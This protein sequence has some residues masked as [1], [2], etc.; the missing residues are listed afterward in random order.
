[1]TEW[2][3]FLSTIPI[4]SFFSRTELEAIHDLF[5]EV[6]YDKGDT[7]CRIGDEG[8]TFY[9]VLSGEL[10]VWG[11][12]QEQRLINTLGPRDFF[13][14]MAILQ[15]GKR[16][17]TIRASRRTRLLS[18]AKADFE[19]LFLKNP[20]AIEYFARVLCKRLASITRGEGGRKQTTVITVTGRPGLKGKTI[21]ATALAGILKDVTGAEVLLV[22]VRPGSNGPAAA[23]AELVSDDLGI[24][25]EKIRRE[26]SSDA[27]GA[28]VLTVDVGQDKPQE[29]YGKG[30]SNLVGK[31]S[32]LFP[33]ILFDLGSEPKAL[34]DSVGAFTD[35]LIEIVDEPVATSAS[36][37]TPDTEAM[38]RLQVINLFN[39]TSKRIPIS[40]CEP[41][42]IPEDSFLAK[43][44]STAAK[45]I[46]E[47]GRTP[48]ALPIHRLARKLLGSSVGLAL[49]GGAAF[50]IAHLGVLKVLE[51]NK[52]PIDLI[53]GCSQGS[54]IGVGYAAGI[55]TDEMIAIARRLGKLKNIL[56]PID[57]TLTKPGILGGRRMIGIFSPLLKGKVTFE[58]LVLPCRTIATDIETGE[59]IAIGTGRLDEAFRASS[60]VPMVFAPF[61][62]GERALVDGGVADPCP[63]GVVHEMGADLCIAV[64]VVPPLK[65]GVENV[66][67]RLYRRINRLNP[68]SYLG[69][70]ADLPNLFDIVM[71]AM[72]ILQYELGNFKAITADVLINPDLSDFT[73]IEYYRA[74]ELIRRGAEAAERV[75]PAIQKAIDE[76]LAPARKHVTEAVPSVRSDVTAEAA[77][78]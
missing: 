54:I 16:T 10:E 3:D 25:T 49:G 30:A 31:V 24:A 5:V 77:N 65:R 34:V 47:N 53:A 22:D 23:I 28:A 50:G 38:K 46:R 17:A 70:S 55:E 41:F 43:G 29:A 1:M 60:S 58:D 14:E 12:G 66:V 75:L 69:G 7:I 20:K 40:S 78:I 52:I 51:E 73:W 56:K 63:A 57:L 13:G 32:A 19:S 27:S 39:R 4:F 35:V 6:A 59:R 37:A 62:K 18:L 2:L 76:K 36:D 11:G 64:N 48:P 61:K 74:E 72:Q 68:L 44:N 45:Y 21:V 15:G 67:S 33:Y 9:V 71:N 26:L 42:V 8:D